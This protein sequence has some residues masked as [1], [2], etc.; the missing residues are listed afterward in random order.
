M[1]VFVDQINLVYAVSLVWEVYP[2]YNILDDM[3]V[4]CT[5]QGGAPAFVPV[6][7]KK[8]YFKGFMGPSGISPLVLN[9]V[10]PHKHFQVRKEGVKKPTFFTDISKKW[11]VF[12]GE[13]DGGAKSEGGENGKNLFVYFRFLSILRP[14]NISTKKKTYF[15]DFNLRTGF[16]HGHGHGHVRKK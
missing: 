8:P 12:L 13:V 1:I 14:L 11:G 6:Y 7:M 10:N 2:N 9:E 3:Y 15:F 16:E 4:R 5:V